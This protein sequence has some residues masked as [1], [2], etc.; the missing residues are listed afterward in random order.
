MMRVK[1]ANL[2]S[3]DDCDYNAIFEQMFVMPGYQNKFPSVKNV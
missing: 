1:S 3:F 2:D